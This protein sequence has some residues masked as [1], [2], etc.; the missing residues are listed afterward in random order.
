M[1]ATTVNPDTV[2]LQGPA[3]AVVPAAVTYD[4]GA[5][6]ATLNPN[7]P[8]TPG[9]TY[10]V[11]VR[12][13]AADPRVKDVAGNALAADA[14][15]T[16]TTIPPP[17]VVVATTP[18]PN[19]NNIPV[20]VAP[21]A[22]FANPIDPA[23][24]NTNTVLLSNVTD[25]A[26]PVPVAVTVSYEPNTSTIALVPTAP[27]QPAQKYRATLSGGATPSITDPLG[28]PLA[29]NVSFAF[30]TAAAPVPTT[31]TI[32][33][34]PNPMPGLPAVNEAKPV[35]LGLKFSANQAGLVTG[36]RFYKG[37]TSNTGQCVGHLWTSAGTKI[38][39]VTFADDDSIG[40]KTALFQTPIL[41]TA[42]TTYVVS[43]LTPQGRYSATLDTFATVG[44][45]NGPLHALS[46]PEAD[47][48]G[49]ANGN[50]GNGVFVSDP[51]V[52]VPD[53][54][55][56]TISF[57]AQNYFVDVVFAPAP[58][59]VSVTPLPGAANVPV[60]FLPTAT[61]SEALAAGSATTDTVLL[62]TAGNTP[63]DISS[64][65]YNPSTF[66]I[67]ITPAQPLQPNQAYTV[68]LKG[69]DTGPSITDATGTKLPADYIWSFTTAPS[70][71]GTP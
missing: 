21:T 57:R 30:D 5:F 15:S 60:D 59:V 35:E 6:T 45:D 44:V 13:G 66:T 33:T 52:P 11:V 36:V 50:T 64:V 43:Y 2:Q 32:F 28:Q 22:R 62:R 54:A 56:P 70:G 51:P 49:D 39:S 41:I 23:T 26:N 16:F 40:W 29:S 12:G 7:S 10:T 46:D 63:V 47:P 31:F 37:D 4:A 34:D 24:A 1:N 25:P 53:G 55:F 65:S 17:P 48:D 19:A 71:S 18:A 8:L 38:D 3:S 69:G 58:Q 9:I 20:N 68:I 67:T 27:L 14:P 42:N 61:F